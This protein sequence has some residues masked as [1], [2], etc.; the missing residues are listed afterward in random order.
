[1]KPYGMP[2]RSPRTG[3][4]LL[5]AFSALLIMPCSV[6]GATPP[7]LPSLALSI[8]NA[9]LS[10][11]EDLV[12]SAAWSRDASFYRPPRSIDVLIY[13]VSSGSLVAG[14]TIP[15]DDPAAA[16]DTA[17]HFRGTVPSSELPEG[18]LLLVVTDPVSGAEARA[19]I[20]VTEPGPDYPAAQAK[21]YAETAFFAVAGV[22][23]AVLVA[24][25]ALLLRHP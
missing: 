17:R 6:S 10:G 8:S 11:D 19:L 22:L 4:F 16:D 21:R 7:P 18:R 12:V 2:A 23:L 3:L 14:Y 13:S 9:T 1:M 24:A 5:V 20:D 15:G 25:L